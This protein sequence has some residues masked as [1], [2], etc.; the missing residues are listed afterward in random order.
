MKSATS[1][2]LAPGND[3]LSA[4]VAAT[5]PVDRYGLLRLM[6]CRLLHR[7]EWEYLGTRHADGVLSW[8]VD[9]FRCDRCERTW[10]RAG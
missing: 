6:E 1:T 10:E 8:P 5:A 4:S 3:L 7:A 9:S 2:D